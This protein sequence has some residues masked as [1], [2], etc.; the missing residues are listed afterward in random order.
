MLL[1]ERSAVS[2]ARFGLDWIV[3]LDGEC[4]LF[5]LCELASK[6][7][8]KCHQLLQKL[9][10]DSLFVALRVQE[11]PVKKFGDDVP[12]PLF[13]VLFRQ[14]ER[15]AHQGLELVRINLQARSS[16]GT[17]YKEL[18]SLLAVEL[19]RN[20]AHKVKA[21]VISIGQQLFLGPL[22]LLKVRDGR[23]GSVSQNLSEL[24]RYFQKKRSRQQENGNEPHHQMKPPV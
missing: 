18:N 14:E 24:E 4:Y 3:R 11:G 23:S 13:I 10:V 8:E 21:L 19:G 5:A 7:K 9:G 16:L 17:F 22:Q 1:F 6:G 2:I 12:V 15:V 20:W